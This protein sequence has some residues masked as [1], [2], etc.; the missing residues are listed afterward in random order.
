MAPICGAPEVLEPCE[1]IVPD[2]AADAA[3]AAA[4]ELEVRSGPAGLCGDVWLAYIALAASV[5]SADAVD[6]AYDESWLEL[7]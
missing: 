7:P 3:A 1:A 2:M 5:A 6:G 4:A